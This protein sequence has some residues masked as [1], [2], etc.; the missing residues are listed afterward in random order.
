ME[1]SHVIRERKA[2]EIEKG[3]EGGSRK[4]LIARSQKIARLELRNVRINQRINQR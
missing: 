3:K 1:S 2:V 4:K